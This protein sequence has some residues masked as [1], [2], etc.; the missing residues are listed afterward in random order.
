M[1]S[2][3]KGDLDRFQPQKRPIASQSGFGDE[4]DNT[5]FAMSDNG[6]SPA[7]PKSLLLFHRSFTAYSLRPIA[8][9]AQSQVAKPEGLDLD[10]WIVPPPKRAVENV[11]L[12]DEQTKRKKKGKAKAKG[13]TQNGS[14]TPLRGEE[15]T[16]LSKEDE[17]EIAAV[18]S[19]SHR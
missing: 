8:K 6:A 18:S 14:S 11:H 1:F 12:H 15:E 4:F 19:I 7:F 13:T 16:P 5:P 9:N 17:A 2:L 3:V 10:L